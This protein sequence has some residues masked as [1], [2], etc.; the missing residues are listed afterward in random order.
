MSKVGRLGK[1][2]DWVAEYVGIFGL[3]KEGIWGWGTENFG[4]F[5]SDT[6][7]I[8]G[9]GRENFGSFGIDIDGTCGFGS[10]GKDNEGRL[11][12]GSFGFGKLKENCGDFNL[13]SFGKVRDGF[14]KEGNLSLGIWKDGSFGRDGRLGV[15][16]FSPLVDSSGGE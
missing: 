12:L 16:I 4:S 3:G 8:W 7:G 10:L 14:L 13:G 9:W 5:G 15:P 6:D 1:V 2:R 11:N